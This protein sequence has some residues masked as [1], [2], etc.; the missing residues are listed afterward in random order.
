MNYWVVG[1]KGLVVLIAGL[2]VCVAASFL[3]ANRIGRAVFVDSARRLLPIYSVETQEKVVSLGFNCAWDDAD[4]PQIISTLERYGI[5]ATF[6]VVGQWAEKYPGS[7]K[8]I[9]EAGHELG[10]HSYSHPDMTQLSRSE[11][12]SQL[13]R[14]SDAVEKAAG[15]PTTLFRAPSGAYNNATIE[16]AQSMGYQV[17]QWSDDTRDWKKL[18]IEQ[19]VDN[20]SKHVK[21][22]SILLLHSGAQNTADALPALI[23]ALQAKGYS[24]RP[25]GELICKGDFTI[26]SEGRQRA[27]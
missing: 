24:F 7:V 19:I 16:V 6:F 27:L 18:S 1:R 17:I 9:H 25:V 4:I 20:G 5:K 21:N 22:G 23:E 11:I 13:R 3:V 15:V 10:N 8:A 26:D 14:C 2:C 12:E